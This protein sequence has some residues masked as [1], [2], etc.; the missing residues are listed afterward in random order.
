MFYA[1]LDI[2][3]VGRHGRRIV[4]FVLPNRC[5]TR[6]LVAQF[7][8]RDKPVLLLL[9]GHNLRHGRWASTRC[10]H[11]KCFGLNPRHIIGRGRR[12]ERACRAVV[13]VESE[14]AQVCRSNLASRFGQQSQDGTRVMSIVNGDTSRWT[15]C[16]KRFDLASS[17]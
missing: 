14:I 7:S 8:T 15:V 6:R 3:F 1:N 16:R 17:S 2:E 4:E 10:S 5:F 9:G 11:R 13:W 12:V